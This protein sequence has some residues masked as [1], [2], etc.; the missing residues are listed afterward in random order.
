MQLTKKNKILNNLYL[1]KI[2]GYSYHKELNIDENKINFNL[3]N[4]LD[5]INNIINNCTLCSFNNSSNSKILNSLNINNKILFISTFKLEKKDDIF[6][7]MLK[8]VLNLNIND[9]NILSLIKCDIQTQI[10]SNEQISI[11]KDYILKQIELLKP[12]L[13]VTL[14]DSYN[15]L[16]CNDI[17][18][19]KIRGNMLKYQNINLIPMYHPQILL[20]NP[21]LK[22]DTLLDLKKIKLIMETF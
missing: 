5:D 4:N 22:K 14:G 13:I 2:M 1:A 7:L 19:S 10:N 21:S 18:I 12:K 9:V 6:E 17:N 15:H 8:N 3:P 20:R 16:L 11:C